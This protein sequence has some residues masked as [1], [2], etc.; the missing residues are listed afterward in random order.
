M[1]TNKEKILEKKI[2]KIESQLDNALSQ[3]ETYLSENVE[4]RRAK[5]KLEI[6]QKNI[7]IGR[8][9]FKRESQE[10]QKKIEGLEKELEELKERAIA[11]KKGYDLWIEHKKRIILKPIK[12][13]LK[14]SV[15]TSLLQKQVK[16]IKEYVEQF[17]IEKLTKEPPKPILQSP[18]ETIKTRDYIKR[19][20]EE[21]EPLQTKEIIGILEVMGIPEATTRQT[22]LRDKGGLWNETKDGW[23]LR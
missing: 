5:L 14:E 22:L 3:K 23:E 9:D 2:E 13:L 6:T 15:Y 4:L 18:Q 7:E 21:R 17:D 19:A 10:R 12:H 16:E 1:K 8:D 11:Y 20:L